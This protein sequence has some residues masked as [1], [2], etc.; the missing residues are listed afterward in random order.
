MPLLGVLPGTGGLTRLLDKR[1]V[2]RDR[3]DL[4]CT[5]EEGVKG[6]RAVDWNLVDELLPRS[7]F[8]D[9]AKARALEL[10]AGSDRPANTGGAAWPEVEPNV[11]A[12]EVVYST[13]RVDFDRELGAARLTVLG[14]TGPPPENAP[15]ALAA[16]ADFWPLVLARELDDALLHLRLNETRLGQLVIESRGDLGAVAAWDG[17]LHR[18]RGHWFV[19]EVLL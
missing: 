19:R 2:R 3:A 4:F 16:S 14:P 15:E 8:D 12:D 17:F 11:E 13:L 5:L 6:R 7:S 18:E 1:R 10:A 9:G